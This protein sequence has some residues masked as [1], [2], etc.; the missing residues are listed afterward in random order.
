MEDQLRLIQT[1]IGRMV[2]EELDKGKSHKAA[3][4]LGVASAKIN[5]ILAEIQ[6]PEDIN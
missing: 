5:E 4:Q 1:L 6:K 2:I 3:F